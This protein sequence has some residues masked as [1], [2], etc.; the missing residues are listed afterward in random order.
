[1]RKIT[2][3]KIGEGHYQVDMRGWVC[4]YPKY[5][6]E[7]LVAKLHNGSRMDMLVDC[8]SATVD[9]PNVAEYMGCRVLEINQI[10]NGEW[11]IVIV[12]S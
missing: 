9:V 10:G 1:M 7:P 5:A 3:A 11:Q 8:P 6:V 4:P 2:A 12:K